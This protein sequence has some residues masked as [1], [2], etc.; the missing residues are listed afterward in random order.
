LTRRKL[1]ITYIGRSNNIHDQKFVEALSEKFEVHEIYTKN[2]D[3]V[4]L[5]RDVFVNAVLIIAGPLTDTIS[6]IPREIDIPVLGISHA[7]DLN[8]EFN[9]YPITDNIER[10]EAIF[11]DCRHITNTL[12]NIYHFKGE[13]YEIPWGCE[14]DYFSKAKISFTEKPQILVTRNWF[15]IYRNE[16]IVAALEYLDLKSIEF[17]CTFVGDGPLLENQIQNSSL[18]SNLSNVRFLKHQTKFEIRDAMSSNWIYISAASSDGTS[19]SLLEAMAAGMI[20]IT[21]DFPSNCEWIEHSVSGF[22]FPDGDSKALAALIQ[23]VSSLSLKEKMNIS[24]RAKE[25]V[26]TKGDWKNNRKEFMSRVVD[27]AQ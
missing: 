10:C 7:F 6:T 13:I 9:D 19:I 3:A 11:S 27:N 18:K 4:P 8:I 15:S 2:L 26:A 16:I 20:C 12:R 1:S 14:N 23:L 21:T 17:E 5:Q 24:Q 25:I 22:I